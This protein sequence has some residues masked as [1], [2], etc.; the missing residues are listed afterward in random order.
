L[1][2][3]QVTTEPRTA[4]DPRL[5]KAILRSVIFPVEGPRLAYYLPESDEVAVAYSQ[6]RSAETEIDDEE[7]SL[8]LR[9]FIALLSLTSS[10][11]AVVAIIAI[12]V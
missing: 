1:A 12:D 4:P 11:T 10:F 7:V 9:S 8:S 5:T 6:K 2:N 3:D